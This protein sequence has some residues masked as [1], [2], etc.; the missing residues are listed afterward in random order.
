MS[1]FQI[2]IP[3]PC[4]ANWVSMNP[5]FNGRFCTNC[6]KEVIDFT[7]FSNA[8]LYQYFEQSGDK[9]CGKFHPQQLDDFA[10]AI[11]K[12]SNQT[13]FNVKVILV[14][15]LTFLWNNGYSKSSP[16]PNLF[17][18]EDKK[19][20]K[21]IDAQKSILD[22]V[23][24]SGKVVD[25]A[26]FSLPGARVFFKNTGSF[27]ET[28]KEG[29]FK[30]NVNKGKT[31]TLRV[32]YIGFVTQDVLVDSSISNDVVIIMKEDQFTMGEVVV[33]GFKKKNFLQRFGSF[34]KRLFTTH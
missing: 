16:K 29:R 5:S 8:E 19:G 23:L 34:T 33:V 31:A 12:K 14:S 20:I 21:R 9:V 17:Y 11:P 30:I 3:K 7:I 13:L 2:K 6:Q 32:G 4:S 1:N 27:V 24:I 28:D 15:C 10:S 25:S 26:G 18:Q 22:S